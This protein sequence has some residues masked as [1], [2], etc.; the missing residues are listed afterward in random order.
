MSVTVGQGPAVLHVDAD[1]TA[2]RTK[3]ARPKKARQADVLR[4]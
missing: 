2:G 3:A 1:E 4:I